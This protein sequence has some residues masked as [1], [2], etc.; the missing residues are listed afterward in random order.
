MK[1]YIENTTLKP[2]AIIDIDG[3]RFVAKGYKLGYCEV[4]PET[5]KTPKSKPVKNRIPITKAEELT[6]KNCVFCDHVGYY[7]CM[8]TPFNLDGEVFFPSPN[9]DD[10]C[11]QGYW[12]VEGYHMPLQYILASHILEE[13]ASD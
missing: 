10:H 3:Q 1:I 13:G 6:C 4:E 12:Y 11:G 2:G 9:K 5:I 7:Q 8:L